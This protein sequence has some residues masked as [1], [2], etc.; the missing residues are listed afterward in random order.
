MTFGSV[1]LAGGESRRMGRDKAELCYNG[2]AFI[3]RLSHEL[4]DYNE[5]LLSVASLRIRV[6][7]HLRQVIDVQAGLGPISGVLTSLEC[8]LS[9]ALLF[10]PCDVP[11]FTKELGDYLCSMLT[12][13]Y[14]GVI[15]VSQ[16]GQ[17]HPLCAVY[18]KSAAPAFRAAIERGDN[19]IFSALENLR[20]LRVN[21]CE[22]GFSDRLLTNV[23]TP[24][25][26]AG[27]LREKAN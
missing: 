4:S 19:R 25:E 12:E 17:A 13:G 3:N 22:A 15:A 1:I 7:S 26:Y 24:D 5:R 16:N 6:P 23:N 10:V 9:D 20:L 8:C 2:A 18:R 14:D 11:L 21:I 27:L